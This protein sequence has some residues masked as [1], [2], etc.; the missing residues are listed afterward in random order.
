MELISE[1]RPP[2]PTLYQPFTFFLTLL[3]F[4]IPGRRR[5]I[6]ACVLPLILMLCFFAPYY[7]TGSR[8]GDY[9][10]SSA[11]A[12]MPLWF[13]DFAILTPREDPEALT[14]V[15]NASKHDKKG[16]KIGKN[17]SDLKSMWERVRWS[18]NLM[19]PSH[20][21][22]GWRWQ[23]KNIP[24]NVD[25]GLPKSNFVLRHLRRAVVSYCRS[26]LMLVI[27]GIST[28]IEKYVR[29]D[30]KNLD[31][32]P[33][34]GTFT[35]LDAVTGVAGATWVWNRVCCFYSLVAALSVAIGIC[36]KCQ[37]PPLMGNLKDAWSVGQTWGVVYHQT[38]R[39]VSTSVLS[40]I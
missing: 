11:Y 9:Y 1:K 22:I 19:M 35:V 16:Q 24:R 30:H 33:P 14:Y 18:F 8:A 34:W 29:Y 15:G 2:F 5:S 28:S 25:E 12:A 39:R 6:A 13:L 31:R 3:P 32:G 20:R 10:G 40:F 37:W 27:L 7:T 38:M 26:T 4:L 36:E 23:V 17:V 21:G